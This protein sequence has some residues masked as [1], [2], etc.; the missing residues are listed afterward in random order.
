[1][2]RMITLLPGDGIGP[3]VTAATVQVVEA[4]G[5]GI[6]WESF[7]VGAEGSSDTLWS[8][9]LRAPPCPPRCSSRSVAMVFA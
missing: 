4:A 1:M 2:S 8:E 5:A 9:P 3:E 6:E 7:V